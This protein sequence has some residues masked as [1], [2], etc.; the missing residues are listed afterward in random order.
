MT[1]YEA[2]KDNSQWVFWTYRLQSFHVVDSDSPVEQ[3]V[4]CEI[5]R[6]LLS[7][8]AVASYHHQTVAP[9]AVT[10]YN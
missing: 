10:N 9:P 4:V 5:L 3:N 6:A 1:Q 7:R 2:N 8:E